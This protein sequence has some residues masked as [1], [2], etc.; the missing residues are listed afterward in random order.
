MRKQNYEPKPLF[1]ERMKKLLGKDFDSY[2]EILKKEP[3]RSF[4]CNTLKISP[5]KL[6][7]RLEKK[8]WRIK[9]PFSNFPEIM[10]VESELSP[11]ELGRAIE[12]L[13]GYYYIQEIASMLPVLVLNPKKDER[14]LD[15]CA[16]PGSKTTQI[17]ARMENSGLL[18]ANE[19][20]FGRLKILA[21]N[22]ERCGVMDMIMT[23]RDGIALCRRF[24]EE[25]FLF[26]KILLDAPCSGEGTIR[27][28]PRTLEMWNIK[29]IENLSKLQKSL[30]ASAVEI[31][32]PNGELVYSTCTH[33]PEEDEEVVDF[34]LKN[35][36]I[37]TEKINLP[38][39]T[40]QGIIKWQEK[41]YLEDVKYSCRVYPQDADTEGFFIAKLKKLK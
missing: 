2:M 12:H 15:L 35:F 19:V 11:G 7:E 34:A 29:T 1:I 14:V 18:I 41:E 6:K 23:R 30:I 39:K 9:I 8:G 40:R 22:T 17:A 4:R 5:E 27:S 33:A 16:S 13:L 37:K 3:V 38:L 25:N 28:T 32:K 24:K 31:L 20:K 10:I 21:A 26:D 36:K